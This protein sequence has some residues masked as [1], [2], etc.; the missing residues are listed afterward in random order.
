MSFFSWLARLFGGGHSTP[1]VPNTP[2]APPVPTLKPV[3]VIVL[4]DQGQGIQGAIV[5]VDGADVYPPTNQ[6]GYTAINVPSALTASQLTVI[7][8]GYDDFTTHV[9]IPA[10]GGDLIV[11]PT[12]TVIANPNTQHIVGQ[13]N[14]QHV[15]P[16]KISLRVLA[17]IRGA[18][19]TVRGPWR[20]GPRPGTPDNITAMGFL[21]CYGDPMNPAVLSQ[22]QK[23]MIKLYKSFGYTH[24]VWGPPTGGSYHGQY[25]DVDF[26]QSKELFE[27]WLD[28]AQVFWDNGLTPICFMHRDNDNYQQTVDL[29]E[30]LIRNNP[31]AQKLMRVIVP[32][33]WEP[34]RYGWSSVTWANFLKWA[35]DILPNALVLIH[36]VADVDAPVGTDE[37][38]DDNMKGNGE[39]WAR[40][41]PYLH[42]WLIQNGAYKVAPSADPTLA[43]NF[44]GQFDKGAIGAECHGVAWH[45][46]NGILNWPHNS[47]WG[48]DETIYLYNAECTSFEAYWGNVPYETSTAWGDLAIASGADGY[49]DSGTVDVP[50]A[51]S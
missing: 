48:P 51:R 9:D 7:A 46:I 37:L 17:R 30:P 44:R 42:G 26:T 15:D 38:Y 8:V 23:D 11:G 27:K 1:T 29:W 45:F 13:L 43:K 14:S 10:T 6:Y 35:R 5:K 28:W 47:A 40:V 31:R 34:T 36:T 41:T 20:F 50:P 32:T 2:P 25:P 19:W 24:V 16:S 49:L 22:E 21:Y 12:T 39:G 33:G 3:A 4:N 18:M